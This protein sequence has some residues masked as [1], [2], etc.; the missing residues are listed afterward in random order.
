MVAAMLLVI[1]LFGTLALFDTSNRLSAQNKD[2][3]G[4]VNLARQAAED[5][6]SLDYDRIDATNIVGD[7]AAAGLI[8]QR[9]LQ[10]GIQVIRGPVTYTVNVIK[11]SG[12]NT[13]SPCVLDSATDG[14]RAATD[15]A[16]F[17]TGSPNAGST[18]PADGNPDDFRRVEVTVTWPGP[19]GTASCSGLDNGVGRSCVMQPVLIQNPSGGIGPSIDTITLQPT[20][21]TINSNG[22]IEDGTA[23]I[24]TVTTRAAAD[25]VHW[26]ADDGTSAGVA[27][28]S[29]K[30]WTFTWTFPSNL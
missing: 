20:G 8:D 1:G 11:T 28:G 24:F 15:S 21:L 5:I 7:L 12:S 27:T 26:T 22:D 13:T 30:N 9:P 14:V 6:R 2:R 29:G 4:A 23:A 3:V 18:T 10:N 16:F 17:C 19:Q 25:E